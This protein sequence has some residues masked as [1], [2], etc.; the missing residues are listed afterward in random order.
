MQNE[1]DYIAVYK[2]H[3]N[4]VNSSTYIQADS[5]LH[6]KEIFVDEYKYDNATLVA[7]ISVPTGTP[8]TVFANSNG[9]LNVV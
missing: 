5:V 1:F 9:F 8:C 4:E 6:A 3:N 2:D 7:I